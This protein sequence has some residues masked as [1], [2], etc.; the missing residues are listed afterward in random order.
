MKKITIMAIM[1]MACIT[2]RAQYKPIKQGASL[3]Y[4]VSVN[5]GDI[6]FDILADSVSENHVALS[7]HSHQSGNNGTWRMHKTALDSAVTGF[8]EAPQDGAMLDFEESQLV[9]LLSKKCLR[10]I[11]QTNMTTYDGVLYHRIDNN[12][13]FVIKEGQLNTICLESSG[14]SPKIWVLDNPQMPLIVKIEGNPY[15]VNI[16]LQ[17]VTDRYSF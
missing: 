11:H 17:S 4:L 1:V 16:E 12:K 10:E 3:H 7:Y 13:P 6:L 14:G 2:T 9:L 15:M 5:N 8:W